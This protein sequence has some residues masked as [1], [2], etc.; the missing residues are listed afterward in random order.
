[1]IPVSFPECNVVLAMSQDDYESLQA[2]RA[3]DGPT[4][5]EF[6]LSPMELEEIARTR[7]LWISVL[8]FNQ[9]FQPIGLSTRC[10]F[11]R[12]ESNG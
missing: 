11:Q 2:Y 5:C 8:T 4:I 6:R 1:M 7:T 12:D 9:A 3:P 10:P